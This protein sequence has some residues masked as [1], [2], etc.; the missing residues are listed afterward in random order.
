MSEG[1]SP[2]LTGVSKRAIKRD[3][4]AVEEFKKTTKYTSAE[5][6]EKEYSLDEKPLFNL[7]GTTDKKEREEMRKKIM[8]LNRETDFIPSSIIGD[9]QL[10]GKSRRGRGSK[11]RISRRG[12][13]LKIRK[14]RG[15][16][17]RSRSRRIRSSRS[18][19]IRSRRIRSRR[20]RSSMKGGCGT[21]VANVNSA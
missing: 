17:F 1:L 20:G 18:R 19:R 21:C 10:G 16:K 6:A 2:E 4:N 7:F 15:S 13:K 5:D 9:D 12:R 3:D 14:S 11:F 8:A